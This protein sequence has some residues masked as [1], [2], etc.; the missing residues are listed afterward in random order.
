MIIRQIR[1]ATLKITYAGYTFLSDPWLSDK[2]T[3]FSARTVI[4]EMAG[5][6]NPLCDLPDT[7][8]NFLKVWTS[9]LFRTFIPTIFQ[10]I[11]CRYQ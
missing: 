6:K 3:G 2:G 9:A 4:P 1:N 8:V 5:L 10:R 11:I 7:P